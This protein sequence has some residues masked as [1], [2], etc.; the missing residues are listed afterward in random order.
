MSDALLNQDSTKSVNNYYVA[1]DSSDE[2]R[3]ELNILL[4]H[5][6][7]VRSE[8]MEAIL[9]EML[10]ELRKRGSARQPVAVPSPATTPSLFDNDG[11]PPQ[12]DRLI[13]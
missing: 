2:K 4:N 10:E 8:S 13:T 5:T 7:N 6:F 9:T 1:K 11:I 12:I 3:Q